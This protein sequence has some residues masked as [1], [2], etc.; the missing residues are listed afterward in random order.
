[1]TFKLNEQ[2]AILG[3]AQDHATASHIIAKVSMNAATLG[4]DAHNPHILA[5]PQHFL[6]CHFRPEQFGSILE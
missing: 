3:L 2:S 6:V 1:M 4:E 5:L